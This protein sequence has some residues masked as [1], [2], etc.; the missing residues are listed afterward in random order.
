MYADTVCSMQLTGAV[1]R[2]D[3]RVGHRAGLVLELARLLTSALDPRRNGIDACE[4]DERDLL[5]ALTWVEGG[6]GTGGDAGSAARGVRADLALPRSAERRSLELAEQLRTPAPENAGE[7]A[8]WGEVLRLLRDA[9]AAAAADPAQAR[10]SH[11]SFYTPREIADEL[12]QAGL[13]T[14]IAERIEQGA[15]NGTGPLEAVLELRLLDPACGSGRFLLA[16]LRLLLGALE[17]AGVET[18]PRLAREVAMQCLFGVDIDPLALCAARIELGSAVDAVGDAVWRRNLIVADALLAPPFSD[19]SFDAVMGNPP[20]VDSRR[21]SLERDAYRRRVRASYATA[22]GNWD[23]FVPFFERGL[24]WLKP[25]GLLLFVAPRKLL[26]SQYCSALHALLLEH[27]PR[28]FRLCPLTTDFG[29]ARVPALW[30]VVRRSTP[31]A[32]HCVVFQ[33]S[34]E[35]RGDANTLRERRVPMSELAGLPA[36]FWSLPWQARSVELLR[37]ARQWRPLSDL[38]RCRDGCTTG[39]AYRIR[40]CLHDRPHEEPEGERWLKVVNSGTIDPGRLLWGERSMR[41]LGLDL[42]YPRLRARDVERIAPAGLPRP[43][44]ARIVVSGLARRLEAA[45]VDEQTFCAKSTVVIEVNEPARAGSLERWLN[46]KL[47]TELYKACFG[48][49]SLSHGALQV[50]PRQLEQ[51]PC[52]TLLP[53]R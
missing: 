2:L 16:A 45:G 8:D 29:G 11:G 12:L 30:S 14:L 46:S 24:R 32:D 9:S 52:P 40:E 3:A 18:P 48:W 23:L 44:A 41:Y 42:R 47:A 39:Q 1:R 50:G 25:A 43:G 31:A 20:F 38:A 36:G 17:R 28:V 37:V 53:D 33:G 26:A 49:R 21:L 22:R 51:L 15:R 35:A 7:L 27:E 10:R 13:E 19:H 4:A 5:T 34:D 6:V